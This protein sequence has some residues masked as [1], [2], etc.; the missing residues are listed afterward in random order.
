MHG[1]Y[2]IIQKFMNIGINSQLQPQKNGEVDLAIR[3]FKQINAVGIVWSLEEIQY[4]EEKNLLNGYLA[5]LLGNFDVAE[6][7]FLQSTKPREALDMRRDLLHWDKA[8]NLAKRLAEEEVPMISKEYAQQ[9]EF[10]GNYS[11][12]LMQYENGLIKNPDESNEQIL[13]H[14][15]MCNSGIARMCIR[16]GDI[17]KGIE[18]A[19]STE[20][21]VVKRDCATILEQLKQYSDAAYLYEL[22]H[23]YDRAAAV[24][25]K[26]KNWT[27]VSSLLPKVHSPKI[28]TAYG[29]VMEGEKK[30]KQAAIAYRNARDYD[31]LVRLLLEH[32]NKPE[33]AVCIVRESRSVEGARLV[34]K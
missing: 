15:N 25:L 10:M 13:E 22:G 33:E 14:N 16:T 8:L 31:N 11:Q 7:L 1:V 9:L 6:K 4:I 24:S 20:G 5:L 2:A 29:K 17:R 23:F 34:A 26:A 18:I 27:K 30:F 12:A 19:A 32:L 28:H 3:I 21:R